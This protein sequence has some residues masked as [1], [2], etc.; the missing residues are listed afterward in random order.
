AAARLQYGRD[1]VQPAHRERNDEHGERDQHENDAPVDSGRA[2]SDGLRRIQGPAGARRAA[3][4]EETRQQDDHREQVETVAQ[5]VHVREHHVPRAE[6]QRDQVVAKAAE[7]QRG[8]QVDHHDHAVHGDE[9][10]IALR[11]DE[12]E[13]VGET[14][15]QPHHHRQAERYDSDEDCSGCVLD[16]DDLVVLA[17]YVLGYE[18]L[19]IVVLYL[20]ITIGDCYVC[21]QASLGTNALILAA[22]LAHRLVILYGRG[23]GYAFGRRIQGIDVGDDVID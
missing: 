10:V 20:V 18:G 13:V 23:S 11:G 17:P 9:L 22:G 3:R 14:E 1:V 2:A 12:G 7:E 19:R 5:H 4:H 21:H 16:C 6:H 15:L 8:Q